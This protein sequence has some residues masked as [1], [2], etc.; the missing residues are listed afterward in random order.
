MNRKKQLSRFSVL[1]I[2]LGLVAILV[3]LAL[4]I[5]PNLDVLLHAQYDPAVELP[6]EGYFWMP[7]GGW[8]Q[9]QGGNHGVGMKQVGRLAGGNTYYDLTGYAWAPNLGWINFRAADDSYGVTVETTRDNPRDGRGPWR[10]NGYAWG[11]NVGWLNFDAIDGVGPAF[12]PNEPQISIGLQPP[13]DVINA[14]IKGYAWSPNFGWVDLSGATIP[15][16]KDVSVPEIIDWSVSSEGLVPPGQ[17][18][19]SG[20]YT[21]AISDYG[22]FANG[23][24][25][26]VANQKKF[27]IRIE[28][29]DNYVRFNNL[30]IA[31]P[32]DSSEVYYWKDK[33]RFRPGTNSYYGTTMDPIVNGGFRRN[34]NPPFD[35][36][37]ENP[38]A[39]D[40]PDVWV[41]GQ[42]LPIWKSI[43]HFESRL[44]FSGTSPLVRELRVNAIDVGANSACPVGSYN[45]GDWDELTGCTIAAAAGPLN[46]RVGIAIDD[47]VPTAGLYYLSHQYQ[48][49]DHIPTNQP[50]AMTYNYGDTNSSGAAWARISW[51]FQANPSNWNI[52]E[53]WDENVGR[54]SSWRNFFLPAV[55]GNDGDNIYFR[56]EVYDNVGNKLDRVLRLV[57]DNTP[58]VGDYQVRDPKD[59]NPERT[60]FQ[61]A[62]IYVPAPGPTDDVYSVSFSN[63]QESWS[64]EIIY[65]VSKEWPVKA[66]LSMEWDLNWGGLAPEV[67]SGGNK[68]VYARFS[69]SSKPPNTEIKSYVIKAPWF[70]A[71]GGDIHAGDGIG[72]RQDF[73]G[74]A[75]YRGSNNATYRITADDRITR[76]ITSAKNWEEEL[77]NA[78]FIYPGPAVGSIAQIDWDALVKMADGHTITEQDIKNKQE[79][80]FTQSDV[81]IAQVN[82]QVNPTFQIGSPGMDIKIKGRGTLLVDGSVYIAG[83]LSYENINQANVINIDS[84]GVITKRSLNLGSPYGSKGNLYIDWRVNKIV[85]SY[86]LGIGACHSPVDQCS[87]T[88]IIHTS[89]QEN[90]SALPRF[91]TNFISESELNLY[92]LIIAR[93]FNMGRYSTGS[94]NFFANA[95]FSDLGVIDP[96]S[97]EVGQDYVSAPANFPPL[98]LLWELEYFHSPHFSFGTRASQDFGITDLGKAVFWMN[99]LRRLPKEVV[100]KQTV[101]I[102]PAEEI[103]EDTTVPFTVSVYLKSN[104]EL[105]NFV[106]MSVGGARCGQDLTIDQQWRRYQCSVSSVRPGTDLTIQ[107]IFKFNQPGNLAKVVYVAA[108]QAEFEAAATAWHRQYRDAVSYSGSSEHFYY[109]G[110]AVLNTPPGFS[111]VTGSSWGETVAD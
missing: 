50:L 66:P 81:L 60:R 110:R 79:I 44:I 107:M 75:P 93:Q 13:G 30:F 2:S 55:G 58:P 32:V 106:T 45:W 41:P 38:T 8:I 24:F 48:E 27:D 73:P 68:I 56:L 47:I 51:S 96:R 33:L 97:L 62:N 6:I 43:S 4:V 34:E 91:N 70:Q 65:G 57:V 53:T 94:Q 39:V 85:G 40:V 109:D 74:I 63:N 46:D 71:E 80:D 29:R 72:T 37:G 28:S 86:V 26:W 88:G 14:E 21:E 31:T 18:Y 78:N 98:P 111:S 99:A 5:L 25:I 101:K 90:L 15:G 61:I 35:E 20:V 19:L 67:L 22:G 7:N 83:N 1:N 76:Q 95:D 69:D 104:H 103:P 77:Y 100:L 102:P 105:R 54:E 87:N 59:L 9:L 10:I 16:W 84:L 12:N 64:S 108:A 92:G 52:L 23:N 49:G 42:P 36:P 11:P 17:P 89:V 82:K 3:L